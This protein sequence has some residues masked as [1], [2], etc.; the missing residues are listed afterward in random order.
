MCG[1]DK[2]EVNHNRNEATSS[3]NKYNNKEVPTKLL[4]KERGTY[5]CQCAIFPRQDLE[6]LFFA[7]QQTRVPH[8][9]LCCG[10]TR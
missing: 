7:S 10:Q 9:V 3:A 2:E 1:D 5:V 6:M 8:R 4:G